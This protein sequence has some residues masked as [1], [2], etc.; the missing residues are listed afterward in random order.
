LPELKIVGSPFGKTIHLRLIMSLPAVKLTA[1][2]NADAGSILFNGVLD[3]AST[4]ISNTR[5]RR[6]LMNKPIRGQT[7]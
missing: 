5:H 1:A 2:G 6:I 4:G 3:L 7:Q